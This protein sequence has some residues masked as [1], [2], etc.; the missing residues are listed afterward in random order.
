MSERRRA[1]GADLDTLEGPTQVIG[2]VQRWEPSTRRAT[3]EGAVSEN[4]QNPQKPRA[5]MLPYSYEFAH[6]L[7]RY[8]LVA[9]PP[10]PPGPGR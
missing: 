7:V 4:T 1:E 3:A 6:V 2:A 10:K 5:G 8:G 9:P